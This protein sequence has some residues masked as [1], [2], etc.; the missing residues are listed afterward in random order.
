MKAGIWPPL[1]L[2]AGIIAVWEIYVRAAGIDP[3]LLPPPSAVAEY[4]V[5]NA[6]IF[7]RNGA[8]T[9]LELL[10]GFASGV[11]IGLSSPQKRLSS[12]DFPQ[13]LGPTMVTNFPSGI[14]MSVPSS[15]RTVRTPSR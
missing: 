13:A 12:V 5:E 15:A 9:L 11:I 1:L 2:G 8:A 3:L 4:L 7:V 6:G 14:S 10:V